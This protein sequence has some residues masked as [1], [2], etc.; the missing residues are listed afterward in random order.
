M[1][2]IWRREGNQIATL[3]TSLTRPTLYD[4]FFLLARA[5]LAIWCHLENVLGNLSCFCLQFCG[6][7]ANPRQMEID[8]KHLVLL[9]KAIKNNLNGSHRERAMMYE[10]LPM[11]QKTEKEWKSNW[12]IKRFLTFENATRSTRNTKRLLMDPPS[13]LAILFAYDSINLRQI[14]NCHLS[15]I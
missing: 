3:L 1:K 8:N 11:P 7:E 4:T 12:I 14:F 15:A 10:E 5:T 6:D 13:R 2:S 9:L